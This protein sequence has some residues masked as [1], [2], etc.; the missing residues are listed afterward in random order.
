[1][2]TVRWNTV[3][4]RKILTKAANRSDRNYAF[5]QK[6]LPWHQLRAAGLLGGDT[7]TPLAVAWVSRFVT[8]SSAAILKEGHK[9]WR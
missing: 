6:N 3:Q 1:M 4:C 5:S 2:R 7:V 8:R 9:D